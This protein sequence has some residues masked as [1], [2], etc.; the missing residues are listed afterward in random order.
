MS[1]FTCTQM[2][3][4]REKDPTKTSEDI[5]TGVEVLERHQQGKTYVILVGV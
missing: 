5:E 1:W 3:A 4:E 2:P